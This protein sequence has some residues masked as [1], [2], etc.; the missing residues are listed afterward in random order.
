MNMQLSCTKTLAQCVNIYTEKADIYI[1]I[2]RI[3]KLLLDMLKRRSRCG[4]A[5]QPLFSGVCNL[6]PSRLQ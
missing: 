5:W 3:I 6:C 4:S 1:Y 2:Y